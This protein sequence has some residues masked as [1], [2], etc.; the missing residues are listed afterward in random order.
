PRAGPVPDGRPRAGGTHP[1]RNRP[2]VPRRRLEGGR[3]APPPPRP[4]GARTRHSTA[5]MRNGH[6]GFAVCLGAPRSDRIGEKEPGSA[7][8]GGAGPECPDTLHAQQRLRTEAPG[9][10][11]G[12]TGQA[13]TVSGRGIELINRFET[14]LWGGIAA[15]PVRGE[16]QGP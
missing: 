14:V 10:R 2:E 11:T 6:P 1:G 5:G 9:A 4:S 7:R 13:R 16:G 3:P 8:V 12:V 15:T